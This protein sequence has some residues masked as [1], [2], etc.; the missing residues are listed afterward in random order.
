MRKWNEMLDNEAVLLKVE[1]GWTA[2]RVCYFEKGRTAPIRECLSIT[3]PLFCFQYRTL[4]ERQ[5]SQ[6]E[7]FTCM[8]QLDSYSH[9]IKSS[10]ITCWSNSVTDVFKVRYLAFLVVPNPTKA[11]IL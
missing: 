10:C 8:S 6:F 2:F 11:K 3:R 4:K 9:G 5:S 7:C 1:T